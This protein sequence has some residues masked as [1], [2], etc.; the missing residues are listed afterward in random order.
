MK[1]YIKRFAE[2]YTANFTP[3]LAECLYKGYN[4]SKFKRDCLAG[5]TVAV[6]SIP[7]AMALAIASGV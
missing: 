2:F 1:E 5:L 4:L 7:L 6:I 3:K